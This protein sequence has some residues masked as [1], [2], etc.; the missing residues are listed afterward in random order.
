MKL[1]RKMRVAPQPSI[2]MAK[3]ISAV[4]CEHG[5]LYVRLH[6]ANGLIFAAACMDRATGFGLVDGIVSEF[7][8][9]SAECGGVH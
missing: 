6:D 9:P 3:S 8:S 7:S 2:R 4:V 5:N 1:P